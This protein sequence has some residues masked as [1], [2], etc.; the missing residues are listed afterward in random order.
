MNSGHEFKKGY[1]AHLYAQ[2]NNE[3]Y[4]LV[5]DCDDNNEQLPIMLADSVN[6]FVFLASNR[7]NLSVSE[8]KSLREYLEKNMEIL[9]M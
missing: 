9:S 8:I 4:A 7:V 2:G 3:S 6:S 1:R 5:I